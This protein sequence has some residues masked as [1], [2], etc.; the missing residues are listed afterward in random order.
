MEAPLLLTCPEADT[1]Q[2]KIL[3]G[4]SIDEFVKFPAVHQYFPYQNFP[5]S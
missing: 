5:F 3:M 1:I 4:E 2:R